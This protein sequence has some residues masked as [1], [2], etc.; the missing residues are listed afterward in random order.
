MARSRSCIQ[1]GHAVDSNVFRLTNDYAEACSTDVAATLGR[2]GIVDGLELG[3][4]AD[5]RLSLTPGV[6][7]TPT[8]EVLRHSQRRNMQVI[9]LV[10]GQHTVW[11][12]RSW[13][14]LPESRAPLGGGEQYAPTR[15]VE[16]LEIHLGAESDAPAA[17]RLGEVRVADGK[18]VA[19]PVQRLDLFACPE[20]TPRVQELRRL[21]RTLAQQ[22]V[23]L[24]ERRSRGPELYGGLVGA[25]G[26]QLQ[27]QLADS[28]TAV[29]SL[30]EGSA[31]LL[32]VVA[33][34]LRAAAP[35]RLAD[36]VVRF[37]R[38]AGRV[39]SATTADSRV[40]LARE[41]VALALDDLGAMG[42]G[43]Q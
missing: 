29:D 34:W 20:R 16:R 40:Q 31:L 25:L 21:L 39:R 28:T 11:L 38:S 17:V 42:G 36:H 2:I 24:Y 37:E 8:F 35:R 3:R 27:V 26:L 18:V 23:G 7:V 33:N 14:G 15:E 6:A 22:S 9:G 41:G 13:I 43:G 12:G 5:G 30:V 19:R 32:E 1:N 10:D 4:T